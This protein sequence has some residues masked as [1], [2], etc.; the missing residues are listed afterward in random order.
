MNRKIRQ[1][2][3]RRTLLRILASFGW[4][5]SASQAD[6]FFSGRK[7]QSRCCLPNHGYDSPP[8][9]NPV[10]ARSLAPGSSAAGLASDTRLVT[11][12]A[13]PVATGLSDSAVRIRVFEFR[14]TVLQIDHCS[15]SQLSIC[16]TNCGRWYIA[17]T[18]TQ[19]PG[20]VEPARRPAF[21]RFLRN[22]FRLQV[23]PVLLSV[24]NPTTADAALGSPEIS[25]CDDQMVWVQKG[26]VRKV[27]LQGDSPELAQLYDRIE[28]VHLHFSIR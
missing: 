9:S 18:A 21:E 11:P 14:P 5:T 7:L 19:D 16:F 8:F 25:V 3:T 20:S 17:A 4:V 13:A 27:A 26:E 23:R 28:R 12:P 15:L 22:Q 10:T 2:T 6:D 1:F 24:S